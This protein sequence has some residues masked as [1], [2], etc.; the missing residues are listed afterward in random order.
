MLYAGTET[1][2][3]VSF[4]DGDRW[5]PLQLNLPTT[6]VR[7]LVVHG[8]D[9]VAATYG[10]ALWIL[11][12]VTPLRQVDSG[13][14]ASDEYLFRPQTALRVRW[15]VN[16]DTPLPPE[17]PAGQNPPDGAIIDYYL[18]SAPAS[19]IRLAI[20]D[21]QGN[22]V[23]QFSSEPGP[24]PPRFPNAPDYW[25]GAPETL[26]RT[27]GLNRFVWDLRYTHPRALPYNYYGA[28]ID[29][30]EYTLADHAI[31]GQTPRDQ[32]QGPL[33]LP[34]Q[35]SVVLTVGGKQYRQP[36]EIKLDPRVHASEAAL[37]GQL[38]LEK[39]IG[40]EMAIS[41]D[42][43]TQI[44]ALRAAASDRRKL[45]PNEAQADGTSSAASLLDTL[46]Q[47]LAAVANGTRTDPGFG[48]VNRDLARLATMVQSADTEPS[49]TAREAAADSCAALNKSLAGWKQVNSQ[50]LP[51]V[52]DILKKYNV[53]V[54]PIAIAIPPDQRC[55]N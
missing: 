40:A 3:Y 35:Y 15:D 28:L 7:D 55:G 24:P 51:S 23:R 10:R 5:Q 45:L 13:I 4:D 48:P 33:A 29:Y 44:R 42:A 14:A 50:D 27:P 30:T 21:H 19:E 46:D 25:F 43:F 32:P 1:G 53:A 36:L 6:S 37:A 41:F 54:L 22:L 47:K 39:K 17:T 18:K 8:D 2:V 49:Q 52:N 12:D 34:G 31:P 20:Y 9:L 38:D 16:Q 11:D 26:L